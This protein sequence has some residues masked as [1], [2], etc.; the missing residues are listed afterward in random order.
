MRREAALVSGVLTLGVAAALS[1][2]MM[3]VDTG[4]IRALVAAL[5]GV[6]SPAPPPPRAMLPVP[7]SI[8]KARVEE[9]PVYLAGNGAVQAYNT[10][11]V[12]SLVDGE[13]TEIRFQEGQD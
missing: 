11:S 9:V 4:R 5:P 10:D 13:I 2:G 12:R 3:P 1:V 8:A 6:G 7:V